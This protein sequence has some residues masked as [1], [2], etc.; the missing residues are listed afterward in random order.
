[1]LRRKYSLIASTR[2]S[3]IFQDTRNKSTY[4]YPNV[5]TALQSKAYRML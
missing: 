4:I 3:V 2:I 5:P 1:M